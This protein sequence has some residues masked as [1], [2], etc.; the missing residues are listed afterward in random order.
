MQPSIAALVLAAGS[1]TRMGRLKQLLPLGD[2]PVLRHVIDALQDAG[3]GEIAVVCGADPSI[4][5]QAVAGSSARLVPNPNEESEMADSLRIGLGQLA[6]GASGVLVCL[7]DHPLVHAGTCR[8]LIDKHRLLPD[9]IVVPAFR[10]R[11]GHPALFPAGV[12]REIFTR[13]SLRDVVREDPGRV[14]T[15]DVGDEGVVLDMD[16]EGDYRKAVE[17]Y[18]TRA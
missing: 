3:V 17:L 18:R 5:Q 6:A 16:T 14:L 4:Y 10:G 1:G 15:V 9:T 2:R 12:I 13:H 7:A 11:R 8:L